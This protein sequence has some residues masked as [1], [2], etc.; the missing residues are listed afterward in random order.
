MKIIFAADRSIYKIDMKCKQCAISCVGGDTL[1]QY[2]R[3]FNECNRDFDLLFST[4]TGD[5]DFYR[6][7]IERGH[8][9]ETGYPRCICWKNNDGQQNCECSRQAL[10][11]LYSQL[12]PDREIVIET[13]QTVRYGAESCI[14]RIILE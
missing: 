14:F 2:Q 6:R 11:Y 4:D 7:I 3:Q 10:V 9:Y 1:N 12:L 13:I 8:I 5:V